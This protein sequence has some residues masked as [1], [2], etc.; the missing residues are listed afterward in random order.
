[1]KINDK[2]YTE[3]DIQ[4]SL[5]AGLDE[6]HLLFWANIEELNG[7][8]TNIF[9]IKSDKYHDFYL[10]LKFVDTTNNINEMNVVINKIMTS[11]ADD[12]QIVS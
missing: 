9:I 7:E 12:N 6:K 8:E 10:T 4:Q 5:A 1:V 2:I 3:N 11:L